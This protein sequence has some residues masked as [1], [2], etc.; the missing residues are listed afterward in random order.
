MEKGP[1]DNVFRCE[2]NV[3]DLNNSAMEF[4]ASWGCF[5]DGHV[6]NVLR[7]SLRTWNVNFGR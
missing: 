2:G 4:C 1:F 6:S 7:G 3:S 5:D